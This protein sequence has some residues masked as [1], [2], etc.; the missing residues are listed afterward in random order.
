[1]AQDVFHGRFC[2]WNPDQDRRQE[3]GDKRNKHTFAAACF[4]VY[5]NAG[6]KIELCQ[7]CAELPRFK[8]AQKFRIP[9]KNLRES[10]AL[11]KNET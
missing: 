1:M 2:D 9:K 4:I 3:R 6:D 10:G 11:P 8:N 5:E 7:D